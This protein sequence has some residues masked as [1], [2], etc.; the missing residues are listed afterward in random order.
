MIDA[1]DVKWQRHYERVYPSIAGTLQR[2]IDRYGFDTVLGIFS[3]DMPT[4]F[5][6]AIVRS[7]IGGHYARPGDDR[8]HRRAPTLQRHHR[9][10]MRSP[11]Y[12][13]ITTNLVPSLLTSASGRTRSPGI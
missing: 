4:H 11:E 9:G 2:L 6:R 8:H 7:G 5:R 1:N 13:T 12:P 10:R 3:S